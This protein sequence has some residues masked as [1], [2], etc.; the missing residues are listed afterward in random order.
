MKQKKGRQL[1]TCLQYGF[2]RKKWTH[3]SFWGRL[4]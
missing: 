1:C 2:T 3:T 4:L